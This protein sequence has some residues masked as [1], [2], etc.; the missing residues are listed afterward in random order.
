MSNQTEHQVFKASKD[1]FL[2]YYNINPQ[3]PFCKI[4][5]NPKLKL[6]LDK[7][8]YQIRGDKMQPI[9]NYHSCAS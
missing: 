8:S 4:F 3:K 2:N 6:T 9:L 1:Q 7:F 5:I